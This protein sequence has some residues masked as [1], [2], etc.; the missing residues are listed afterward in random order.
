MW[1]IGAASS[2][3]LGEN[4]EDL[5][6]GLKAGKDGIRPLPNQK[7]ACLWPSRE[8]YKEWS[9][10]QHINWQLDLVFSSVQEKLKS[11]VGPLGVILASTKGFVEDC[12][13]D[14]TQQAGPRKEDPL[15]PVLDE[16]LKRHGSITFEKSICVSN[17]CASFHAATFLAS[18]WIGRGDVDHVLVLSVDAVGAFVFNGFSSLGL[19]SQDRCRPFAKDRSGLLLGEAAAAV[20]FSKEKSTAAGDIE[21]EAVAIDSEGSPV[22]RP[23]VSGQSLTRVCKEVLKSGLPEVVIAHGTGTILNDQIEDQVFGEVF[24]GHPAPWVLATKWSVGHTLGASGAVDFVAAVEILKHQQIFSIARTAEQDPQFKSRYLTLGAQN[25]LAQDD[26]RSE[27]I[28]R[29]MLTSLGF[30]GTHA[31]MML[32]CPP[33]EA[34]L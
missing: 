34:S 25:A 5:W 3:S 17:A 30:G 16:F 18:K 2:T 14:G 12:L 23:S 6:R 7:Q 29:V 32:S 9:E 19:V 4:P 21:V 13:L 10:H 22:S 24:K 20:L 8:T 15:W 33:S 11:F 28:N 27:K 1:V 26:V 31:A